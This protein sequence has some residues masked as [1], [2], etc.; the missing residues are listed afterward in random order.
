MGAALT[1]KGEREQA[2]LAVAS[3]GRFRSLTEYEIKLGHLIP[4]EVAIR[5]SGY[6]KEKGSTLEAQISRG[7][8][9]IIRA[10]L[11]HLFKKGV[12]D[13][14]QENKAWGKKQEN[15]EI[16]VDNTNNDLNNDIISYLSK[17]NFRY[18]DGLYR[19]KLYTLIRDNPGIDL[20]RLERIVR[21]DFITDTKKL[22]QIV[23]HF[24]KRTTRTQLYMEVDPKD[25]KDEEHRVRLFLI[26][27]R[28]ME[29]QSSIKNSS[30]LKRDCI[31]PVLKVYY[32][33]ES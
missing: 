23:E 19:L 26:K 15:K 17:R 13:Y 31:K 21:E 20:V 14:D 10:K 28:I 29:L 25:I 7:K 8:R 22:R 24:L 5:N 32:Y 6:Y 2:I 18:E 12:L 11:M 9:D 27:M 1:P 4:N 30:K 3:D 16:N 33:V